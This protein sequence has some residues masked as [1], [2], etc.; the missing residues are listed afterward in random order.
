MIDRIDNNQPLTG[1]SS[2]FSKAKRAFSDNDLDVSINTDYSS[3]IEMAIKSSQ[4]DAEL[5]EKARELVRT[6]EL[7]SLRNFRETAENIVTFGI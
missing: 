5:I 1:A 6:G 4:T 2:M 3:L 7:E